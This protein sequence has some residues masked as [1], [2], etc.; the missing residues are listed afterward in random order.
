MK[1][2]VITVYHNT[3]GWFTPYTAGHTL[4]PV[5]SHHRQL[6]EGTDPRQIA[7]WVFHVLNADLDSLEA[8]RS[9]AGGESAFLLACTYRLMKL[10]SLAVGDVVAI[11]LDDR[12]RWLTCDPAAWRTIRRAAQPVETPVVV[13]VQQHLQL[14]MQMQMGQNR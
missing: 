1:L 5:I 10:R 13:T 7:E 11:T 2:H 4:T 6:P 14:Q 12:T 9:N 3:S 8:A